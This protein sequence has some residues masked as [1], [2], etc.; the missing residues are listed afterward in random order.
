MADEQKEHYRFAAIFAGG[1][2]FSR[3]L[4]LV[5]DLTWIALPTASVDAFIVAFRLP[6]MLRE[7]FGEGA[8]NAAFIPV[9]SDTLETD[10]DDAFRE[11][12]SAAMSAMLLLLA[13]LTVLGIIILPGLLGTLDLL[14]VFTQREEISQER[15]D[16]MINLAVWTFPYI[17]LIG[18]AIFFMA[19]LYSIKHFFTPSWSPALLNIALI[20]SCLLLRDAFAEPA[21][22]LVI[23]VWIGGVAQLLVQYIT[24]GIKVGVWY[25]NFHLRH[26]GIRTVL[27]LMLPVVFGQSA[28]ELNRLVDILFAASLPGEGT[29]RT[30]YFSNRLV[31]LPLSVF[32][33]ATSVAIF[34]TMSR[35]GARDD[36]AKI[37][38]TLLMG[39]R[40]SF[41]LIVPA[42]LGLIVMGEPIIR[43]LFER[44]FFGAEDTSRTAAALMIYAAGLLSFA[45]VKVCV[46]GFYAVKDTRTPVIIASASM[47]CNIL[48]NIVLIGPLGYKGLALATTISFT[49]NAFF[50]YLFL[51][52]K[53]GKM[54][55]AEFLQ[56]LLRITIAAILMAAVTYGV[57]LNVLKILPGDGLTYRAVH[58]LVP[59]TAAVATYA[60]LCAA[61]R[62]PELRGFTS[63]LR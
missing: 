41:F 47:L 39:L 44:S 29:V 48:L 37:R 27:W 63:M 7:L 32:G 4:G 42:M 33:L 35:F 3:V 40:L 21:F 51:W 18:M 25:P 62:V 57:Y 14:D 38:E 58:V 52:Q 61:L 17:F 55:D 60:G 12:V 22:A 50:L 59:I 11:L 54:Y 5:R 53:F 36:H 49:I 8:S 1:T 16:L 45:W 15:I 10:S 43:L 23:G 46:T 31:Q 2:M 28:G 20:A 26:P 13:A 30:L 19:P 9:F 24:L 56:S 6:N 34:P